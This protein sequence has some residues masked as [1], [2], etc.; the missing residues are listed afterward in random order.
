MSYVEACLR[1]EGPFVFY[2]YALSL[3][4]IRRRAVI[5]IKARVA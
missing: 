2:V 1:F 3:Y 5:P 4:S